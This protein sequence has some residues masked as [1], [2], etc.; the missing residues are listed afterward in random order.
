MARIEVRWFKAISAALEQEPETWLAYLHGQQFE[1]VPSLR[2]SKPRLGGLLWRVLHFFY[3]MMR[4]ASFKTRKVGVDRVDVLV[5]AGTQNQSASLR[6]TVGRLDKSGLRVLAITDSPPLLSKEGDLWRPLQFTPILIFRA[7]ILTLIR[8]SKLYKTLAPRN[9]LLISRWFNTFLNVYGY[10]ALFEHLLQRARPQLVLVSNDHNSPNRAL[11]ALARQQSIRVAYLQHASVSPLFPALNFD[12][13]FLDGMAALQTYQRCVSNHPPSAK[14]IKGEIFLTGQKK[15][16]RKSRPGQSRRIGIALNALDD[17]SLLDSLI[18]Q[19]QGTEIGLTIRWHPGMGHK[20][21]CELQDIL[22]CHSTVETSDPNKEAVSDFLE[23]LNCL[24]AGNSSIHLEAALAHVIPIYYEL[25][26]VSTS[27]YYGYV[28]AGVS[29]QA[30]SVTDIFSLS[31]KSQTGEIYLDK[32]AIRRYSATYGTEW[33]G[34]EG[35]LVAAHI[36]ALL[37]GEK[38]VNLVGYTPLHECA[39]STEQTGR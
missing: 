5:Y 3:F 21:I 15:I 36:T 10:L 16:L 17:L 28:A 24:I 23:N 25:G 35:E 34:R 19:L 11:C 8:G 30:K 1:A 20:K 7:L 2:S 27:D 13:S 18:Y 14:R 9:S 33:E 39:Y 32:D 38:P 29:F 4:R 31:R 37:A 12:Y 6:D 22:K 26:A